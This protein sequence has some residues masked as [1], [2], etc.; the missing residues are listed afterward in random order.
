MRNALR[1]SSFGD[2]LVE[3]YHDFELRIFEKEEEGYPVEVHYPGEGHARGILNLD[4]G[5]DKARPALRFLAAD[6]TDEALLQNFGALLFERLFA[7]DVRDA[8][9]LS[10]GSVRRKQE[11]LR[12]RLIVEPPEL[13]ALPWEYLYD[14]GGKFF[15]ATSAE[16]P[17]SRYIHVAE[18]IPPPTELPLKILVV[19][20][21]PSDLEALGVDEEKGWIQQA[22]NKLDEERKVELEVLSSATRQEIRSRL[23]SGGYHVFHFIG[24]GD[25]YRNRGYLAL[26]DE[27]SGRADWMDEEDFRDFFLGYRTVRL[28]VLNACRGAQTSSREALV[29]TAPRLVQRGV[30]AVVAMRYDIA[31]E[32]AILF[33]RTFYGSLAEGQPVDVAMSTTR[34]AIWQDIGRHRRD[35]GQPV[36]FMRIE[37]GIIATFKSVTDELEGF[38]QT[39]IPRYKAL[40]EWKGLHAHLQSFERLFFLVRDKVHGKGPAAIQPYLP[41]LKEEWDRCERFIEDELAFF[42][43]EVEHIDKNWLTKMREAKQR[44]GGALS[45]AGRTTDA[46]RVN[47]QLLY[48]SVSYL[49]YDC[50][51]KYLVLANAQLLKA[52][53]DLAELGH[54]LTETGRQLGDGAG[55]EGTSRL[56]NL[57]RDIQTCIE[58]QERLMG[59]LDLHNEFQKLHDGFLPLYDTVVPHQSAA[60]LSRDAQQAIQQVTMNIWRPYN[61]STLEPFITAYSATRDEWMTE[62][63]VGRKQLDGALRAED[64]SFNFLRDSVKEWQYTISRNLLRTDRELKTLAE[65]LDDQYQALRKELEI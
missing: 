26:I 20:S 31:D 25:F 18:Q 49:H 39:F 65:K 62:I 6:K 42:A 32:T 24:H 33:S 7:G 22:L 23:E 54:K 37:D 44:V 56:I 60:Q 47:F 55:P 64:F 36:L 34:R 59:C 1:G 17:L 53:M 10:L 41:S 9:M 16:I 15:L 19:I 63:S 52:K 8:L 58:A 12:L 4:P 14:P 48:E 30:P 51:Q 2:R 29:G 5:E 27:T 57:R 35:F 61:S 43:A 50:L 38:L 46:V 21:S 40:L 3:K 28:V 13:A 11:G 45:E